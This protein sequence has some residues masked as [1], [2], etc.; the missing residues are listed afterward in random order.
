MR[1]SEV[2]ALQ[3]KDIDIFNQKLTIGKTLAIDKHNQI[4]IQEPKTIS[5][6]RIIALDVKTINVIKQCRNNRKE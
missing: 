4:I 1:K 5:S 6:Q 3:W 2:L